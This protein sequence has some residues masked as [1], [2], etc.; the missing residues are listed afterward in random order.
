MLV[1]L[2]A[3]PAQALNITYAN[4]SGPNDF[5]VGANWVGGVTPGISDI[6]I[7]DGV[8]GIADYPYLDTTHSIQRFTIAS[9]D[10]T[11]GGLE[12]RSGGNLGAIAN[13]VSYVGARGVGK[14]RILDGA[15]LSTGGTLNVGW[16]DA[17]GHG[18]GEVTQSGGSFTANSTGGLTLG[19]SAAD[20]NYPASV[21]KYT[22][23]NGTISLGGSLVVGMAGSGTFNMNGGSVTTG[24]FL[25]IGRTGTGTFTHKAGPLIVNRPSGDAMVVGAVAGGVGTYEISGGSLAVATTGASAGVAIGIAAGTASGTFKVVGN[26][27]TSISITGDYKQYVNSNLTLSIGAGITPIDLTGNA[28]LGGALNVSFTTT[29][30][31]GQQFTIMNYG[32]TLTGNFTTF[33]ALVDSPLGPNTVPLSIS[34][35]T[36]SAS[37]IVL[38]VNAPNVPGDYDHNGFVEVADYNLW[39]QTFGAV[40]SLP[41]DGNGNN[42]VDAADYVFWRKHYPG[43]GTAA[44]VASAQVPE[45]TSIVVACVFTVAALPARRRR[46][47]SA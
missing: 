36:G 44:I 21:G 38:T 40:G 35:G 6:P 4:P 42:V 3:L 20:A 45:P 37:S 12:L 34:Y 22:L 33:D 25:Q 18:N 2:C 9:L 11:S 46:P 39:R 17:T 10:G 29:P 43:S 41:A 28:L 1:A 16:G 5:T 32:G 19:V 31:P 24:S 23:D 15:I 13:N 26:A 27:P 7:I 14:L 8:D 30:T 47:A